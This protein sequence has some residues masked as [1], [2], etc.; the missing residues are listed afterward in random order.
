MTGFPLLWMGKSSR[1]KRLLKIAIYEDINM[2]KVEELLAYYDNG[3]PF[4]DDP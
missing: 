3:E 1:L 2:M 4:G